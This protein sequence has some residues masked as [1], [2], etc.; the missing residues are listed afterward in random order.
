MYDGSMLVMPAKAGKSGGLGVDEDRAF[1]RT[2]EYA[3]MHCLK[4][5]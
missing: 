3:E 4:V 5:G 1:V 2:G